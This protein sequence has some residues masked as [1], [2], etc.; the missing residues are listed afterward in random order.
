MTTNGAQRGL[1]NLVRARI[2]AAAAL[3]L[4]AAL[5]QEV[6]AQQVQ[7]IAAVVND[8]VISAYDLEQRVRLLF[9]TARMRD[10]PNTRRRLRQRALRGLIDEKLRLQEARR[11]SISVTEA[12]LQRGI[13]VVEKQNNMKPGDLK[14]FLASRDIGFDIFVDRLRA[15]IAWNKLVSRRLRPALRIG[16]DEIDEVEKQVVESK[17]ETAFLISEIFLPVDSIDNDPRVKQTAERIVADIQGGARFAEMARQYSEGVTAFEGGDVG[18]V[19]PGQLAPQIVA[20]LARIARG[21]MTPPIQT[22]AGY[23]IV[24]LRDRRSPDE[25]GRATVT[26]KQIVLPLT[27]GASAAEIE[28]QRRRAETIAASINSC[29]DAEGVIARLESPESG[30]LGT[31]EVSDLPAEFRPV[32]RETPIG[33]GSPPIVRENSIHVLVVCKRQIDNLEPP[34][35]EAIARALSNT[36]LALMARRYLRDL[37]RDATVEIRQ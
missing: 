29:S 20:V 15:E 5:P 1:S 13:D 21:S 23:F 8:E 18:W 22:N 16:E 31:L 34:D 25:P 14:R 33:K 35:R 26:L 4:L 32:V 11:F 37:R 19:R 12:D 3:C 17:E 28:S 27:G 2:F 36:R 6:S 24:E 30:D 10:T 9:T 7:S